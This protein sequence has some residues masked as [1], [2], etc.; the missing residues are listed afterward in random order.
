MR[1]SHG[2]NTPAAT[3]LQGRRTYLRVPLCT[4][5][6]HI[7]SSLEL[8]PHVRVIVKTVSRTFHSNIVPQKLCH[9]SKNPTRHVTQLPP[10]CL[11]KTKNP[12]IRSGLRGTQG[13]FSCEKPC[14]SDTNF[15]QACPFLSRHRQATSFLKVLI[16]GETHL[17]QG[18]IAKTRTPN[19]GWHRM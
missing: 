4:L 12:V 6:K 2:G 17:T 14:T 5:L 3:D 7:R 13:L 8:Q 16:E 15:T 1:T 11:L 18:T 10:V 19:P 9:V